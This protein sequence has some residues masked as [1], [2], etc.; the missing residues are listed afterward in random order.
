MYI[1]FLVLFSIFTGVAFGIYSIQAATETNKIP[2]YAWVGCDG[3]AVT[4]TEVGKIEITQIT[5]NL[6]NC[7]GANNTPANT[8]KSSS[9]N[10][11]DDV[12]TILTGSVDST[13][14]II[15]PKRERKI[16]LDLAQKDIVNYRVEMIRQQQIR[17]ANAIRSVRI[18]EGKS[19]ET[20][21]EGYLIKND[22]VKVTGK[23]TG[24]TPVRSGEVVV[25]DTRENTISIDTSSGTSG[26]TATK[27]LR[28][29]TPSDLVKIGQ[30]DVAYWSDVVHTNV[31][32]LV[33]IR[34][35]PWYT[36]AI[37]TTVTSNV[38]L[39]RTATVDNW[40]Q[41]ES[42]D[43]AIK[44]FIKSSFIV[45]DMSQLIEKKPLLK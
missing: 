8:D 6:P 7:N 22:A 30:A 2:M 12:P 5:K 45:V 35:N 28:D 43:G 3:T 41:V 18:R 9:L 11:F 13:G 44:W 34:N 32:H 1:R 4:R 17:Y 25:T 38:P 40:S 14:T 39:Y 21:T 37:I 16:L 33:N 42:I 23:V 27:W 19:I 24:W 15:K 26:Y 29:A 31:A 10:M 20:H 36:S